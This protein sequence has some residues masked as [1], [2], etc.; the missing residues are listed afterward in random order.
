LVENINCSFL[1]MKGRKMA[2]G[3]LLWILGVPGILI[4]ALLLFGFL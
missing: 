3:L 1:Q 2:K 4:L